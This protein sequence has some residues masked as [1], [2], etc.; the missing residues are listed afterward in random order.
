MLPLRPLFLI[1]IVARFSPRLSRYMGNRRVG[2]IARKDVS[3]FLAALRS[4]PSSYGQSPRYRGVSFP[5]MVKFANAEPKD[6]PRLSQKTLNR[7]VS[8]ISG[9][10][11]WAEKHGHYEGKNPAAGFIDKSS[12][13]TGPKRRPWRQEELQLLLNGPIWTGSQSEYFRSRPGKVVVKDGKFWVP[14]LGLY[15]GLRMEEACKLRA[16]DVRQTAGIW[17]LDIVGGAGGRVKE[18]S[19][20]RTVPVHP[21]LVERTP[22]VGT[23][24]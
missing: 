4:L 9:M 21:L 11:T 5:E 24:L 3:G 2:S 1:Q 10:F 7:H 13:G 20:N 16:E 18:D 23:A 8:A 22:P 14:L 19:S 15:A 12:D 6:A 17:V